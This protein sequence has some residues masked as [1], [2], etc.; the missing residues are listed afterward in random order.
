MSVWI[1]CGVDVSS[2]V[3]CADSS[4]ARDVP[5]ALSFSDLLL[6]LDDGITGSLKLRWFG[7]GLERLVV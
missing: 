5:A 2:S 6:M 7:D 1:L 3:S 4:M